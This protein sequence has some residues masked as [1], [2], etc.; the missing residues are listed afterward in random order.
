MMYTQGLKRLISH[1]G[2]IQLLLANSSRSL[3]VGIVNQSG[4]N[5]SAVNMAQVRYS[6][7]YQEIDFNKNES[8]REISHLERRRRP[9]REELVKLPMLRSLLLRSPITLPPLL[10]LLSTNPSL[11]ATSRRFSRPPTIS[12]P[13]R[14]TP[15]QAAMQLSS[16]QLPLKI[17]LSMMCL[18]T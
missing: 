14:R 1:Q 5:F 7:I 6:L 15:F 11:L 8:Y 18:K 4:Q 13:P 17:K 2:A 3:R 12:P 9:R 16:S 10:T